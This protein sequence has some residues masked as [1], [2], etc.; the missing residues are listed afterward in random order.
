MSLDKARRLIQRGF[1]QT[2]R[3]SSYPNKLCKKGRS[4][5]ILY[6][7]G[8]GNS[9]ELAKQTKNI[10]LDIA[11]SMCPAQQIEF[12]VKELGSERVLFGTDNPFIDPRAQVGRVGLAQIP[13]KDK[14]NIFSANVRRFID[15]R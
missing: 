3:R 8:S 7:K 10:F 6:Q 13:H 9:K 11:L 5:D 15:F 4:Q 2:L 1:L 14:V 12:F